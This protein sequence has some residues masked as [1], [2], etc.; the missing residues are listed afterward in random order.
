M[1]KRTFT[2]TLEIE[3]VSE[4]QILD[5]FGLGKF[6]DSRFCEAFEII[7]PA[8]RRRQVRVRKGTLF[9]KDHYLLESKW[10][11]EDDDEWGLE[12]AYEVG[13]HGMISS[14]ILDKIKEYKQVWGINVEII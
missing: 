13:E 1:N 2:V 7:D 5:T 8:K 4:E 6:I 12:V 10:S 9:N 3:A 14:S 11:D